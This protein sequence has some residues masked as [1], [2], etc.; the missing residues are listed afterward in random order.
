MPLLLIGLINDL[1]WCRL[2]AQY[3]FAWGLMIALVLIAIVSVAVMTPNLQW[4]SVFCLCIPALMMPTYHGTSDPLPVGRIHLPAWVANSS[5][6]PHSALCSDS[7]MC[8]DRKCDLVPDKP[9]DAR[10]QN[11][12][13]PQREA[14]TW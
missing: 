3:G 7:S 14:L 12:A 5:C 13:A 8:L 6:N 4:F 10:L 11:A 1:A 9:A 2:V